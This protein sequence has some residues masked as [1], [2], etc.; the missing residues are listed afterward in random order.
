QALSCILY[1][2]RKETKPDYL[3][4]TEALRAFAQKK[5]DHP[6]VFAD[7]ADNAGGGAHSRSTFLVHDLVQSDF[8]GSVAFSAVWDPDA[9][10]LLLARAPGEQLRLTLAG[11]KEPVDCSYDGEPLDV[12]VE[13]LGI[14]SEPFQ[15][16][17]AGSLWEAGR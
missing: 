12:E 13:I 10:G 16:H 11:G 6:V 2:T 17:C 1:E 4:F 9:V 15:Q 14:H 5:S 8:E 7:Y 3:T